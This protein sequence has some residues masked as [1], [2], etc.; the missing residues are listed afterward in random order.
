M[1]KFEKHEKYPD[2]LTRE[3]IDKIW[4]INITDAQFRHY[5]M[6]RKPAYLKVVDGL[7]KSAKSLLD[8]RTQL[9]KA[10]INFDAYLQ[11][12]NPNQ[13]T[14]E[15]MMSSIKSFRSLTKRIPSSMLWG[16]QKSQEKVISSIEIHDKEAEIMVF[17]E[18]GQELPKQNTYE[19]DLTV[20]QI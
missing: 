14:K 1:A 9:H 13:T 7:K 12:F 5:A 4:I 20:Y 16:I 18:T 11:Y 3:F 17:N 2:A 10:L 8:S 15:Q 6:N 19:Y